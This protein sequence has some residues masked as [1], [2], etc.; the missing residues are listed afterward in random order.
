MNAP[1][2]AAKKLLADAIMT[3]NPLFVE[4]VIRVDRLQHILDHDF[5]SFPVLN[6]SGNVMGV[7]P[8][9]FLIVLLQHHHWYVAPEGKDV[10][11][12]YKTHD[13]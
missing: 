7:I 3:N 4:G 6:M 2:K 8:K 10:T 5:S 9:N 12:M 11:A 1:P 13:C